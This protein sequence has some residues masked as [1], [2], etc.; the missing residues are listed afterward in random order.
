[1]Q[2]KFLY[3]LF[4]SILI[5]IHKLVGKIKNKLYPFSLL[6]GYYN[7]MKFS[8]YSLFLFQIVAYESNLIELYNSMVLLCFLLIVG[9]FI[10]A[11]AYTR[12]MRKE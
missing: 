6:R 11:V 3:I 4:F 5:I 9:L 8:P 10:F 1:M 7:A 12:L 2:T